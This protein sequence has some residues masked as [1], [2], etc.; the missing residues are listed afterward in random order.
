MKHRRFC[1]VCTAI[2][3]LL[4]VLLL[5]GAGLQKGQIYVNGTAFDGSFREAVAQAIPGGTV[6]IE[7][8]VYTRPVGWDVPDK[9][10]LVVENVTI[11]G[12]GANARLQLEP[13]YFDDYSNKT[14]VLT[15]RGDNV[16][17]RN[18]HIN[19]G[20]RVDFPLRVFGDNVLVEDVTCVGGLRGAVNILA[21]WS[22]EKTQTYRRVRA[23][24]SVQGG[25]YFDDDIDCTGLTLEGCVTRGNLRVGVLVRNSYNAVQRLDLSGIACEEGVWAIEDRVTGTIGGAPRADISILAG[26]KNTDG[27]PIPLDR[28]RY[29]PFIEGDS[30]RHYRFGMAKDDGS[31]GT[32][33]TNRYGFDVT[34]G[35]SL[36]QSDAAAGD[37]LE[38][39]V[40][41]IPQPAAKDYFGLVGAFCRYAADSLWL[42][43]QIWVPAVYF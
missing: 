36:L 34:L 38:G 1:A 31:Y 26:P 12:R 14:D 40:L 11:E 8:T 32:I 9:T 15:I 28:A 25:F 24:S 30:Y 42:A 41:S 19:A 3:L 5:G 22:P 27:E 21:L 16:T 10:M 7:G 29:I 20:L 23:E 2:A 39:D 18:L 6:E 37:A 35:Y 43:L 13:F 33:T 4:S 17:V